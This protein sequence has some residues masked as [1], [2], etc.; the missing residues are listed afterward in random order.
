MKK[1][2]TLVLV[3][4]PI[5]YIYD[6]GILTLSLAD[7]ILIAILPLL[8]T[9]MIIKKKTI[10]INVFLFF[11]TLF[12][13]SQILIYYLFNITT[14]D[15][16]MTT[17]RLVLY[18]AV[19]SFFVYEYFDYNKGIKYIKI[20]ATL[21]A[22][23]W[24]IQYVL[25][26]YF[27]IFLQGT[28]PF[29]KTQVDEYNYIMN[30]HAWSSFAYTRPRSFFAEPSHF[31]VYEALGLLMLLFK[32][33]SKDKIPT[34]I[35]ALSMLLSGSGMAI[36]LITLIAIIYFFNNAKKITY[37]K[38]IIFTLIILCCVGL[39]PIYTKTE[40]FQLFFD[41]TFISKDSTNG[42]FG[43]FIDAFTVNRNFREFFIGDGIYKIADISGQKYITSIPRI[44]T[45]FGLI[46][47]IVFIL[48]CI[49]NFYKLNGV[50]KY[51]WILLFAISFASEIL[52]HSFILLYLPFI[53]KKE[54]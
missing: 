32:F 30:N 12:I 46:G 33:N 27:G 23:F 41:R 42:R 15:A 25:F 48:L 36:T 54:E 24:L 39:L 19:I 52:F 35:V 11:F 20:C 13:F 17:F 7:I 53:I 45:Y 34:I 9:D 1:I 3:L 6:S 40:T 51:T 43:N 37:N 10:K 44:Y 16:V 28:L 31:A 5:L 8:I 26:D 38:I 4:F 14:A 50:R 47:L 21:S 18:Y 22:I 2:F 49:S 29:F